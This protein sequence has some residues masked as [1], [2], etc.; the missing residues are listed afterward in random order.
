MP[1]TGSTTRAAE[2]RR[3]ATESVRKDI[4]ATLCLE[5]DLRLGAARETEDRRIALI[6]IG[7]QRE[8]AERIAANRRWFED[9]EA[10][11]NASTENL[12]E[13]AHQIDAIRAERQLRDLL[14]SEDADRRMR[15]ETF[16]FAE[17]WTKLAEGISAQWRSIG[18]II[19][20]TILQSRLLLAD[21]VNGFLDD[22]TSG[23][24]DLLKTLTWGSDYYSPKCRLLAPNR[25]THQRSGCGQSDWDPRW[26]ARM[27]MP[28]ADRPRPLA[29]GAWPG[30]IACR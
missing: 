9:E 5:G 24:A 19:G 25:D 29:S 13:R 8:L 10:R 6:R 4:L 17:Y 14:A 12:I 3:K 11:I 15:E 20:E 2:A 26:S 21:T 7:I 30:V 28:S 1:S 27:P 18:A 22:L 16:G 23:Q